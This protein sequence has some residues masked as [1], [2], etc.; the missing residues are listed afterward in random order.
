MGSFADVTEQ[1]RRQQDED[2]VDV[3]P[4]RRRLMRVP[5][6]VRELGLV[7]D[8]EDG[9]IARPG[10]RPRKL[11]DPYEL[12]ALL[13]DHVEVVNHETVVDFALRHHRSGF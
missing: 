1:E 3:N 13:G 6:W 2:E 5:P 11:D 9:L 12:V 4:P 10:R 8:G 7:L